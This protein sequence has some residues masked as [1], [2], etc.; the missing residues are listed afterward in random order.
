MD[1]V[2][3][4]RESLAVARSHP[5]VAVHQNRIYV[6]GGGGPAFKSLDSSMVYDPGAGR[7]RTISDMPSKRSGTVAVCRDDRIYVL[8]GGFKQA[9]GQFRFLTT[10][11]VYHPDTDSWETGPD[12]L[13]PHDYP[14]VALLNNRIYV[15][16]GHHPEAYKAGPKTDPGFDFCER[17]NLDT[18]Q[19]EAIP[20]LPT[21]RFA[22][23]AAVLDGRILTFGGVAFSKAGFN[24]YDFVETYDPQTGLWSTDESL[25]LPWP[26]AGLGACMRRGEVIILGGYS[27]EGI[28]SR[29]ARFH[30]G[31]WQ[32]LPDMPSPRAAMGVATV[33]QGIFIMGGWADDGRTPVNDVHSLNG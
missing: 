5:A 30:Q 10:V 2:W 20:P 16:G 3:T 14:A 13:Q 4:Q 7:W 28:H 26:A 27:G 19:W 31:H 23:A 29:C 33:E 32:R 15:M 6:F 9:N 24:N 22:L 18:G 12:L 1:K 21:P 17:L 11:E 25:K 8:G